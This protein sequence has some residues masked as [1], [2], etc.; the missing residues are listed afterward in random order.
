MPTSEVFTAV[1]YFHTTCQ[2]E[3]SKPVVQAGVLVF[4]L[5]V[6]DQTWRGQRKWVK[7]WVVSAGQHSWE[8][9]EGDEDISEASEA[10]VFLHTR[11]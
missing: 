2:L 9:D 6:V 11:Q 7:V 3:V 8:D 5:F 1:S 10:I 4:F